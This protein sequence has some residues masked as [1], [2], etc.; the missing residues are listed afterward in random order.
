MSLCE[1]ECEVLLPVD[2]LL[3]KEQYVPYVPAL[4]DSITHKQS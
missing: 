4:L 1:Q 2:V 3:S